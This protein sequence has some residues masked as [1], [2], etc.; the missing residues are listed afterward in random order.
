MHDFQR[1]DGN[2]EEGAEGLLWTTRMV[3]SEIDG[4][5]SRGANVARCHCDSEAFAVFVI[6]G[7]DHPHLQCL[8][9]GW[10]YCTGGACAEEAAEDERLKQEGGG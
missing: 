7:Q 3:Q 4:V 8:L 9:C 2:P 1:S 5:E 6:H 10:V